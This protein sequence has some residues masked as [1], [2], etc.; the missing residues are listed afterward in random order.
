[1]LFCDLSLGCEA[2]AD[3]L[4]TEVSDPKYRMHGLRKHAMHDK[5][6]HWWNW[7]H[8]NVMTTGAGRWGDVARARAVAMWVI[9]L[10]ERV[11]AMTTGR[12]NARGSN[13]DAARS[14][15][16]GSTGPRVG[17]CQIGAMHGG[18]FL[19]SCQR[20]HHMVYRVDG[21][22]GEPPTILEDPFNVETIGGAC[23][24]IRAPL[25]VTGQFACS[26]VIDHPRFAFTDGVCKGE[27]TQQCQHLAWQE[28][29]WDEAEGLPW[30]P[31]RMMG[32]S[33]MF[34]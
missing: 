23:F 5:Y 17:G 13:G 10:G 8:L 28:Q 31:T 26:S 29:V 20:K 32:R 2:W 25:E 3:F 7:A 22:E 30:V 11:G 24:I 1:M 27:E 16:I 9:V 12:G 21:M 18:H 34:L 15:V 4:G 33:E 19:A 14:T 6:H